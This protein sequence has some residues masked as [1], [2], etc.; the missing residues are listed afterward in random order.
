MVYDDDEYEYIEVDDDDDCDDYEEDDNDNFYMGNS[1]LW[2][3]GNFLNS[4]KD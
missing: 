1:S 2:I 4:N 3:A